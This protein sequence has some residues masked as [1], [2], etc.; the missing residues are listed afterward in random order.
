MPSRLTD[1]ERA[2]R[3]LLES[4]FRAIVNELAAILGY[5][6]LW[7]G[8]LRTAHGWRTPTYGPLGEGWPDT[9][10]IHERTGRTIYVEFKR[11]L[12]HPTLKQLEVHRILRAAGLEVYVWR[13]SDWPAIPDILRRAA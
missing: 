4:D 2:D 12:E 13:P 11:E 1:Q 5:T 7:I 8:A 10:Y 9:T 3:A 6:F